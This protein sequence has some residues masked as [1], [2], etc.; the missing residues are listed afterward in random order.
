MG[1]HQERFCVS[2]HPFGKHRDPILVHVAKESPGLYY[3]ENEAR[4]ET[5]KP[6]T[7]CIGRHGTV[8][9]NNSTE[10]AQWGPP[11]CF[12]GNNYPSFLGFTDAPLAADSL[13]QFFL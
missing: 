5:H 9:K 13:Q 1:K 7:G 2:G 12:R 10:P 6:R 8:R 11:H 4:I 3:M